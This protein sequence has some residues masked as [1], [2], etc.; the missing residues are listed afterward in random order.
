MDSPDQTIAVNVSIGH[1]RSMDAC[2]RSILIAQDVS[3]SDIPTTAGVLLNDDFIERETF[4][5]V[6]FSLNDCENRSDTSAQCK[7]IIIIFIFPSNRNP[8]YQAGQ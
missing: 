1:S 6:T 2:S 8:I 4:F 7:F 5:C 3:G